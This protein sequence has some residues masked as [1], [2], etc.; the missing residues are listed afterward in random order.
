MKRT[1]RDSGNSVVVSPTVD[2]ILFGK[3]LS[4]TKK[5][6]WNVQFG[7]NV[8]V[9][10]VFVLHSEKSYENKKGLE[11]QVEVG[12]PNAGE[13]SILPPHHPQPFLSF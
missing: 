3:C 7:D 11:I 2:G 9:A 1:T 12:N 10:V 6:F 13:R 4:D 8:R 5:P